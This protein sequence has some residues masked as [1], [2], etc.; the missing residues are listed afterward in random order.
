[1]FVIRD[2]TRRVRV[3]C[4][5][6]GGIEPDK[7][8]FTKLLRKKKIVLKTIRIPYGLFNYY[9]FGLVDG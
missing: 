7:L 9:G 2:V 5:S 6:W 8:D 3:S 1:M 4:V